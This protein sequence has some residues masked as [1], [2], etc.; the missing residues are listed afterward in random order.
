MGIEKEKNSANSTQ[1]AVLF[2][3][4]G[5]HYDLLLL[6]I[7]YLLKRKGVRLLYLGTDISTQNL[8]RII[9]AKKPDVLYTYIPRIR[10][11]KLNDF[12][13]QLDHQFPGVRLRAV[14]GENISDKKPDN[15]EYIFYK[16]VDAFIN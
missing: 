13:V 6:Y 16:T 4:K 10:K 3:Q 12:A 7:S 1:S 5:E 11:S 14:T 15:V 2:L 8:F 9:H